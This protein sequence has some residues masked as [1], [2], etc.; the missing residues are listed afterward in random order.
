MELSEEELSE[1]DKSFSTHLAKVPRSDVPLPVFRQQCSDEA[2]KQMNAPV[3]YPL[4][5]L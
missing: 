1:R 2:V 4:G 3:I 5:C